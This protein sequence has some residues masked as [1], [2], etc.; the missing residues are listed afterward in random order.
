MQAVA[1]S[2]FLEQILKQQ[3]NKA[4]LHLPSLNMKAKLKILKTLLTEKL[5]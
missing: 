4:A 2:F 1:P 5:L 3:K